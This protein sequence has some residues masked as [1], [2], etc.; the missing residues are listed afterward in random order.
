MNHLNSDE[1]ELLTLQLREHGSNKR[2]IGCM[3][4]KVLLFSS[5]EELKAAAQVNVKNTSAQTEMTEFQTEMTEFQELHRKI[6]TLTTLIKTET[7]KK[8]DEL[9]APHTSCLMSISTPVHSV[10]K[11]SVTNNTPVPFHLPNVSTG[12][13]SPNEIS[14]AQR[15]EN[16]E[17]QVQIFDTNPVTCSDSTEVAKTSTETCGPSGTSTVASLTNS[18]APVIV[19]NTE[20]ADSLITSSV[21]T[22]V[23]Q[24]AGEACKT[25]LTSDETTSVNLDSAPKSIGVISLDSEHT[26]SPAS[27]SESTDVVMSFSDSCGSGLIKSIYT[28][29][30]PEGTQMF[31]NQGNTGVKHAQKPATSPVLAEVIQQNSLVTADNTEMVPSI[32]GNSTVKDCQAS[33][34]SVEATEVTEVINHS[35]APGLS[36][37]LPSTSVGSAVEQELQST[38]QNTHTRFPLRTISTDPLGN[39]IEIRESRDMVNIPSNVNVRIQRDV[40]RETR[41]LASNLGNFAWLL[42][43]R[44]YSEQERAGKNYGGRGKPALSPRRKE[45]IEEAVKEQYGPDAHNLKKIRVA[46]DSGMR[47]QKLRS[48]SSVLGSETQSPVLMPQSVDLGKILQTMQIPFGSQAYSKKA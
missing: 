19:E 9:I 4:D 7:N 25:S 29:V 40:V 31:I 45:A 24:S 35:S 28:S 32:T 6:D 21:F 27:I 18:V 43:K 2:S 33:C 37:T 30:T 3:T 14:S 34:S 22:E 13:D 39:Y 8:L 1:Q 10:Y 48:K 17:S 20:H 42:A 36:L 5:V 44:M 15:F 12:P 16:W 46:I 26:Q 41:I 23:V 11:S 47:G 38:E